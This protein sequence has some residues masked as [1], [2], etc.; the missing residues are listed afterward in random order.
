MQGMIL[1]W[2]TTVIS[3]AKPPPCDPL[4]HICQSPTA[5][6]IALLVFAFL[7]M[8]IGAGGVR[9][10]SQAFG[11]DQFDQR[12]NPK[13]RRVLETF[14]NWYYASACLSVVIAL[15]VIVYIQEHLGWRTGF[16]IPA[17]LMFLS[18]VSFFFASPF[19]VKNKVERRLFTSFVRV[20]IAAYRNRKMTMPPPRSNVQYCRNKE[21]SAA[22]VPTDRLRYALFCCLRHFVTRLGEQF[23]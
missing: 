11:A 9:P 6:Q 15:T 12:D 10:C 17:I 14:F 23:V 18:V 3:T 7:L 8:S 21:D 2:L 19:Y 1:L 22:T 5:G 16:G 20:A 13:N 4:A